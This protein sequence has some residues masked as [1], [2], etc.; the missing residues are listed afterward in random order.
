MAE[1]NIIVGR[2]FLPY[3]EWNRVSLGISHE[4]SAFCLTLKDFRIKGWI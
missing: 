1:N 2:E 4:I 3:S